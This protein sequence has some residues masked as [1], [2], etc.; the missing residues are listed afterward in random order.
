M[1]KCVDRDGP[2][3]SILSRTGPEAGDGR[4]GKLEDVRRSALSWRK[5]GSGGEVEGEGGGDVAASGVG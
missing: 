2:V 4:S 1:R 3:R 5:I